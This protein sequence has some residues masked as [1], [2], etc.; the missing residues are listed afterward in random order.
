MYSKTYSIL[1]LILTKDYLINFYTEIDLRLNL[2][3]VLTN[4]NFNKSD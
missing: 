4:V 1:L 3:F 2:N